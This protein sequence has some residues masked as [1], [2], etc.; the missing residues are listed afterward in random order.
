MPELRETRHDD[1]PALGRLLDDV[2]RRSKGIHDQ[3]QLTD[4]PL[5]FAPD[6]YSNSR[7]IVEDG[8]IVSHAA[9]W[10]RELFVAGE[11]WKAA[12]IVSVATEPEYRRRGLAAALMQSLQSTLDANGFDFAILWT[13]VPDFYRKLGWELVTPP[14]TIA[15][16]DSEI[17]D[18]PAGNI[19]N[20]EFSVAAFDPVRHLGDVSAIHQQE[21]VRFTRSGDQAKKLLT[22]PKI[23]VWVATRDGKVVA[24]LV[25]GQACNKRGLIEYG[26]SAEGVS[27]LVRHVSQSIDGSNELDWMI[28][29]SNYDLVGWAESIGLSCRRL[30]SSKGIG[31]EMI[32]PVRPARI[33]EE[34]RKKLFVWGLDWA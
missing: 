3:S 6:N 25:H 19:A 12:V 7:V 24:Y 27:Y 2:F 9:L 33:T 31:C 15:T 10:P 28:F 34:M 16:I 14:G 17:I 8:R 1:I 30:E 20:D 4:F 22:L 29:D 18:P 11:R 32:L 21:N 13:S 26:G 23:Q 5:V